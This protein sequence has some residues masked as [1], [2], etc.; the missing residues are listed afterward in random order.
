MDER[1]VTFTTH[2]IM[3]SQKEKEYWKRRNELEK[4]ALELEKAIPFLALEELGEYWANL[5]SIYECGDVAGSKF[6]LAIEEEILREAKR[7]K[8]EF[9]LEETERVVTRKLY[10]LK[11]VG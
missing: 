5:V 4:A 3:K 6:R 2:F 8:D 1:S 7:L 9:E 11:Y 10:N